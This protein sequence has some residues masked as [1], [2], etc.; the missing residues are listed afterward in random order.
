LHEET[1]L[2]RF[3]IEVLLAAAAGLWAFVNI[4]SEVAEGDT[5]AFDAAILGALRN[6]RDI[7]SPLGP[8]WLAEVARGKG[9][10]D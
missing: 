5:H 3:P 6:P 9:L 2:C 8:P 10:R 1:P 7:A 4:A